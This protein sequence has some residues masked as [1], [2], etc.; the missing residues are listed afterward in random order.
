MSRHRGWVGVRVD[1]IRGCPCVGDRSGTLNTEDYPSWDGRVVV[2]RTQ[3][4]GG[5]ER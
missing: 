4:L 5:E 2:A 3:G 1:L